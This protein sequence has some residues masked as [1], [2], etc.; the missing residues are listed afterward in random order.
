M[1]DILDSDKPSNPPK[2]SKAVALEYDAKHDDA[3]RITATG[4]GL[5]A[6]QILSIAFANGVRVREDSSLIEILGAL[7]VDSIIPI[8]AFTAVAEILNYVYHANK[9]YGKPKAEINNE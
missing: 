5:I 9:I 3:P 2:I 8:E 4:K 6:E 7:E 1:I